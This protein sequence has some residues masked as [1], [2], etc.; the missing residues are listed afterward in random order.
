[1]RIL[2]VED[3]NLLAQG[4]VTALAR[5][6][7][8]TEHCRTG[9]QALQALDNAEFDL[10]ILDLGLPDGFAGKI[11]QLLKAPYAI[12]SDQLNVSASIGIAYFPDDGNSATTL[13]NQADA[14]MYHAKQQGGSRVCMAL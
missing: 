2:L 10:M 11:L 9:K 3:D 7:Y 14:A 8:Q 13:I 12:N 6:S 4:I 5:A 1:M